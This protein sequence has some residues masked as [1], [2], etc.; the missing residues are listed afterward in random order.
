MA[1]NMDMERHWRDYKQN[2]GREIMLET[3]NPFVGSIPNIGPEDLSMLGKTGSAQAKGIVSSTAGLVP[4]LVGIVAG[5]GNMLTADPE[6]KG[7]W[8][9]FAAGY[10]AVPFTPEKIKEQFTALGWDPK[11]DNELEQ[12]LINL[13]QT[14]GDI[15]APGKIYGAELAG[16]AI[17]STAKTVV[18]TAKLPGQIIDKVSEK[19]AERSR[20]KPLSETIKADYKRNKMIKDNAP[21]IGLSTAYAADQTKKIYDQREQDKK[22]VQAI[23]DRNK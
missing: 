19:M 18:D 8:A 6:K 7:N 15:V 10:D 3:P 1:D 12:M 20:M 9:Q 21:G 22:E 4:A 5:L 16:K 13:N 14:F 23:I 17:K 2:S 11:S